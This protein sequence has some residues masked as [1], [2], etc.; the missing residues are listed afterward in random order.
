MRQEIKFSFN[1]NNNNRN[2][3]RNDKTNRELRIFLIIETNNWRVCFL[4]FITAI[5]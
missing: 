2:N 4:Y 3:C 5:G 1:N